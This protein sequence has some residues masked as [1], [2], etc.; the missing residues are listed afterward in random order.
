MNGMSLRRHHH[1]TAELTCVNPAD[2]QLIWPLVSQRLSAATRRTGI[3]AF[4]D[5]EH[6][7]LDGDALLWLALSADGADIHIDAVAATRLELTE[8]GKVCVIVVC[9]GRNMPRWLPLIAGIEA[10]ANA[11]GC[12]SVRIY[13]RKG[14]LRVL[15]GYRQT[16]VIMEKELG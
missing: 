8:A 15:D 11:E 5:I 13:G 9:G 4:A 1:P 12:R 3:S 2:V 14:W 6:A 7:I 16:H 10:Y